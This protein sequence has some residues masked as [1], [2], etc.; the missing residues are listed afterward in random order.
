MLVKAALE[1]LCLVLHPVRRTP[2]NKHGAAQGRSTL[3]AGG[4][5]ST[6]Y[7]HGVEGNDSIVCSPS[8]CIALCS[9]NQRPPECLRRSCQ[10]VLLRRLQR[11]AWCFVI[12]GDSTQ[13]SSLVGDDMQT[14]ELQMTTRGDLNGRSMH[15]HVFFTFPLQSTA[16]W[17]FL[18]SQ[19]PS[20]WPLLAFDAS[21]S[22]SQLQQFSR[23]GIHVNWFNVDL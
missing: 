6:E 12:G 10:C 7:Q 9:M 8:L 21:G 16:S 19:H 20:A 15:V 18:I 1:T 13:R 3:R 23:S 4:H 11:S 2:W 22:R 14:D 5:R 17:L